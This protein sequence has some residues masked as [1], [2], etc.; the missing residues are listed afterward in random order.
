MA[1]ITQLR[2]E[3]RST[4]AE[5][6]PDEANT[7]AR[8]LICD[9]LDLTLTELLLN[10]DKE[11]DNHKADEIRAMAQRLKEHE[12]LQY[13]TGKAYFGG[14]LFNVTPATLIPRPETEQLTQLICYTAR[15]SAQPT[16]LDIGTG[17]GCIAITLKCELPNA[18]VSAIDISDEALHQAIKNA[19]KHKA[20][21]SFDK[22]DI[23]SSVPKDGPYDIVVSNPPYICEKER[24]D[25]EDNVLRH[26]PH[27]A[28][29]VPD[30]D[31]LLFYRRIAT[32]CQKENLLKEG[33]E[34]YFE[35][36]EAYGAETIAMLHSLGYTDC[37]IHK[38][39][40]DK[41]RMVRAVKSTTFPF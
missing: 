38:D 18:S 14:R 22:C 10:A 21:V 28:L 17:S 40:Y 12:P 9:T 23:L 24:A 39:I 37:E 26:E 16:I 41:N 1:T 2:N 20:N 4:I 8:D 32:V 25:M 34:L 35:I 19:D 33:G 31:P 6:T 3:V 29:F 11:V 27:T 7:L 36:N 30:D 5:S 15:E 13:V